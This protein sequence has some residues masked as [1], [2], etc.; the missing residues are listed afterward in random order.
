MTEEYV[1]Q[2]LCVYTYN[3]AIN[4][5]H[6]IY[7]EVQAGYTKDGEPKFKNVPAGYSNPTMSLPSNSITQASFP[8]PLITFELTDYDYSRLS[9]YKCITFWVRFPDNNPKNASISQLAKCK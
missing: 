5:G 6:M 1:G 3:A 7:Q 2:N 8:W 9:G 4:P